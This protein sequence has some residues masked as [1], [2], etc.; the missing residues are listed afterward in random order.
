MIELIQTLLHLDQHLSQWMIEYGA[1]IYLILFLIVFCETGLVVTPFLPGDSLLF[2]LGALASMTDGTLSLPVLSVLLVVAAFAGDNLNYFLGS[3]LGQKVLES[4]ERPW[5]K[6]SNIRRTQE[7]MAKNGSWAIILARFVPI[8]R[9][10]SPFVAG[11]GKM[12]RKQF[13]IYSF[14]GAVLWTQIFL[15]LGHIFGQTPFVKQ[16]FP[17]LILAVIF[18]SL[19]PLIVAFVR[20]RT[21]V[22]K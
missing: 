16:N 8:V 4:P 1:G 6:K 21:G 2:A 19:I 14:G 22:A 9:T 12:K 11:L 18:V 20:V 17:T 3:Q 7:F 5:L 13:L 10:F 15:W